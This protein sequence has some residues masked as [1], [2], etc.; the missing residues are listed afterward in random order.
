MS[1]DFVN[2]TDEELLEEYDHCTYIAECSDCT[3]DW[4]AVV[5]VENELAARNISSQ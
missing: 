1:F 4:D 2:A 3:W 5:D